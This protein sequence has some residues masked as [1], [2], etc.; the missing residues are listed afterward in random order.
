MASK[1]Q[2]FTNG[3]QPE[4]VPISHRRTVV[5]WL[6][7]RSPHARLSFGGE[8]RAVEEQRE[9]VSLSAADRESLGFRGSSCVLGRWPRYW[10]FPFQ[11]LVLMKAA[12]AFGYPDS[13]AAWRP[14]PR[15]RRDGR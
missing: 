8:K 7:S 13:L 12:S 1:A 3:V 9:L 11:S 15:K 14:S 5:I 6:M 4:E 2:S 10:R